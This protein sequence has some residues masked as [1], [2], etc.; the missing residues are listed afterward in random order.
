[1]K[2]LINAICAKKHAGGGF[3]I[4]LNFVKAAINDTTKDIE[5]YF[6]LS[7]HLAEALSIK[8]NNNIYIFPAQPDFK[9]TYC[10]VRK[11]IRKVEEIIKPDVVYSIVAPSYFIFK[12]NYAKICRIA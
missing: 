7:D 1:M 12:K 8:K 4:S 5:W 11:K 10:T 6:L 3:Q 2:I 9:G